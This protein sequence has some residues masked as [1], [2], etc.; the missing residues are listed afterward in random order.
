MESA[1]T[2]L[3]AIPGSIGPAKQR[4]ML[5]RNKSSTASVKLPGSTTQAEGKLLG[6]RTSPGHKGMLEAD[7]YPEVDWEQKRGFPHRHL[8]N[9]G[10]G[11]EVCW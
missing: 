6:I 7:R 10:G 9:R 4:N 5:K 11:E 3:K 8:C 1:A 2:K